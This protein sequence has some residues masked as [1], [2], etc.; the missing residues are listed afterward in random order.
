MY[1]LMDS[2]TKQ[3]WEVVR[4]FIFDLYLCYTFLKRNELT[5][6]LRSKGEF[7]YKD[8]YTDLW[9]IVFDDQLRTVGC[10]CIAAVDLKKV[11][12]GVIVVVFGKAQ[13]ELC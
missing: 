1:T 2:G 12:A 9:N 4:T 5:L 11:R 8:I 13:P 7:V 6:R 10:P 3:Y